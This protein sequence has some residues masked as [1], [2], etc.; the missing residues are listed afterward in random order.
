M[1]AGRFFGLTALTPLVL[2]ES[3]RV[4]K[5]CGSRA[6][7]FDVVDFL[8]NCNKSKP[9]QFGLSGIP[10]YYFRCCCCDFMFTDFCDSWSHDDFSSAIYNLDYPAVDPDYIQLRPQHMASWVAELL[11]KNN[12][13]KILDYGSGS[14]AF[15][16]ALN[17]YG[18]ADVR[19][20]DPYSNP[21]RPSG[22]F[23]VVTCFEV[24]EHSPKP[25]DVFRDVISYLSPNGVV[26]FSQTLQPKN[27]DVVRCN[28]WYAGPRNGHI[29][30]FSSRTLCE[31]ASLLNLNLFELDAGRFVLANPRA[32]VN[33]LITKDLQRVENEYVLQPTQDNHLSWHDVEAAPNGA[34][35][36]TSTVEIKWEVPLLS[37]VNAIAF[38]Y[39]NEIRKGFAKECRFLVKGIE[40]V[41]VIKGE[42]LYFEIEAKSPTVVQ[43][44]LVQPALVSPAS[45]GS[46]DSRSLGLAIRLNNS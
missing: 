6:P 16:G 24:I 21:V 9:Y 28:W 41:P 35:R 7:V 8:K 26:V 42:T 2:K 1:D 44:V 12:E 33:A 45:Y 3:E 25:L 30:T 36:W 11:A 19:S 4:C 39:V 27:I 32:N 10:V 40:I 15:S 37:G 20:Y 23:D 43:V 31:I 29:S 17:A 14:G 34:F 22:L 38:P 5:I 13:L 18:F 46:H